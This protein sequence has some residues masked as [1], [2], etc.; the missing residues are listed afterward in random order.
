[1][2]SQG[3]I[4]ETLAGVR[5][6]IKL[7]DKLTIPE[8]VRFVAIDDEAILM[9]VKTGL[10]FGLD[11]VGSRIWELIWEG[12]SLERV[13]AQLIKEYEV[14]KKRGQED[15]LALVEE[16]LEEDLVTVKSVPA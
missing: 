2:E 6:M 7:A 5:I 8:H 15:V 4:G 12:C 14:E 3:K 10:L 16:L 1:M 9:N 11:E 13:I